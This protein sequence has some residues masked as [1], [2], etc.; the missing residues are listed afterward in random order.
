MQLTTTICR[1]HSRLAAN[2]QV[3]ARASQ[4]SVHITM[5]PPNFH[6]VQP[7][8][9][10]M[11]YHLSGRNERINAVRG[12][13]RL[14]FWLRIHAERLAPTWYRWH[15]PLD[16]I[17]RNN[18]FCETTAVDQTVMTIVTHNRS[19]VPLCHLSQRAPADNRISGRFHE[20][21]W[22]S[23]NSSRRCSQ[24]AENFLMY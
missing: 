15:S 10:I 24:E 12:Y 20:S 8:G 23:A 4:A 13:G 5:S 21:G 19:D 9:F 7:V 1:R 11:C 17:L 18:G 6:T 2:P 22:F 16:T 3:E 14:G